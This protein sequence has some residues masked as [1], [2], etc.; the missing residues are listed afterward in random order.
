M[1]LAMSESQ[2]PSLIHEGI[3]LF[4]QQDRITFVNSRAYDLLRQMGHQ[5]PVVGQPIESIC[6]GKY[7]KEK[8][9]ENGMIC[10]EYQIGRLCL[11]LKV[12]SIHREDKA[13]GGILLLR[14]ISEIKEKDKQLMI[15]SAVIKEIHHR[16]KNNLQTIASLMRLQ[17][18]R[19]HSPEVE[20][21]FRESI[22][23][24]SSIAIVHEILAQDGLDQIDC[25][26]VVE[27]IA[28]G[29]VSSMV[30]PGQN[31]VIGI[32]GDHLYLPSS[33]ATS[34]ALIVNE[35]IQNCVNHAFPDRT[36]GRIDVK[37]LQKNQFVHVSVSDN[38]VGISKEVD[39]KKGHLGLQIVETLVKEQLNGLLEFLVS[40]NGTTVNITFPFQKEGDR[41]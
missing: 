6:F 39:L 29:I 3:I 16:V 23:R 17:M 41:E 15:K 4:D 24:I 28:R 32:Q 18:R 27:N 12:V 5:E 20:K 35:L 21:I 19:S 38:G 2:L 14:D 26:D 13:V 34:I 37:L 9:K 31:I 33:E 10:D 8:I 40:E 7:T 30:K 22:N 36:E 11:Q 25:R 1:Q